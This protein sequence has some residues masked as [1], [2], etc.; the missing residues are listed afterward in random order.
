MHK[1]WCYFDLA[2]FWRIKESPSEIA[3]YF[4]L[5]TLYELSDEN[6]HFSLEVT[7]C[8]GTG[9]T[10]E[11]ID[12]KIVRDFKATGNGREGGSQEDF[13]STLKK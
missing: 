10:A 6:I 2:L 12:F 7:F 9:Q 1:N 4:P 13:S 8:R 3:P 5:S 11:M